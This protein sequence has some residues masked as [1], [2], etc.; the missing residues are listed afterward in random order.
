MDIEIEDKKY[1][2]FEYEISAQYGGMRIVKFNMEKET[3]KKCWGELTIATLESKEI[4]IPFKWGRSR[5]S[6]MSLPEI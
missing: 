6:K 5:V 2:S 4:N 1:I 3:L